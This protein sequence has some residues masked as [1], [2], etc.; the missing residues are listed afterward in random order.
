MLC[1]SLSLSYDIFTKEHG[2]KLKVDTGAGE[3]AEFIILLPTD[4]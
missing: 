1:L 3:Y 2:G 4:E